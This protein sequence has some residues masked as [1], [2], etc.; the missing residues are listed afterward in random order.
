MSLTLLR[1]HALFSGQTMTTKYDKSDVKTTSNSKLSSLDPPTDQTSSPSPFTK[2]DGLG[3]PQH[4]TDA[5]SDAFSSDLSDW[6]SDDQ[7]GGG[8]DIASEDELDQAIEQYDMLASQDW[9]AASQRSFSGASLSSL[10]DE[11]GAEGGG[12]GGSSATS[13]KET[14]SEAGRSSRSAASDRLKLSF[15]DPTSLAA[16]EEHDGDEADESGAEDAA[17]YSLMLESISSSKAPSSRGAM[18]TVLLEDTDK[19]PLSSRLVERPGEASQVPFA[20]RADSS[21]SYRVGD[22]SDW[23]QATGDAAG[24]SRRSNTLRSSSKSPKVGVVAGSP[25][26]APPSLPAALLDELASRT[27]MS[28]PPPLLSAASTSVSTPQITSAPSGD[29]TPFLESDIPRPSS[30]R[31]YSTPV[32][33][34]A[35]IDTARSLQTKLEE[36]ASTGKRVGATGISRKLLIVITTAVALATASSLL[37]IPITGFPRAADLEVISESITASSV[38]STSTISS[39]PEPT[40]LDPVA[41]SP[42]AIAASAS[43]SS[44]GPTIITPAVVIPATNSA[45]VVD[46]DQIISSSCPKSCGLSLLDSRTSLSVF[47]PPTLSKRGSALL[48]ALSNYSTGSSQDT[49][50]EESIRDTRS[51]RQKRKDERKARKQCRST[52]SAERR[53]A[54]SRQLFNSR[55]RSTSTEGAKRCFHRQPHQNHFADG[56]RY[57]HGRKE[58]LVKSL[59][60]ISHAARV[61]VVRAERGAKRLAARAEQIGAILQIEGGRTARALIEGSQERALVELHQAQ[62]WADDLHRSLTLRAKPAVAKSLRRAAKGYGHLRRGEL[63]IDFSLKHPKLYAKPCSEIGARHRE[64]CFAQRRRMT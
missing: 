8:T 51:P 52:C 35:T 63:G 19:T 22:I 49:P 23:V 24:G 44:G 47:N 60:V 2:S 27:S 14:S 39:R 46:K 43:S 48:R 16:A 21:S 53:R 40:S 45:I 20:S 34:E 58:E 36:L 57:I 12:G 1:S 10:D 5:H 9:G 37:G 59:S 38:S 55:R 28:T 6:A 25:P 18:S 3:T 50:K 56:H 26:P 11:T 15:P 61:H 31:P 54:K 33:K 7:A 62:K 32:E 64:A 17:N 41:P 13:A 4:S 29:R 42:P 30:A